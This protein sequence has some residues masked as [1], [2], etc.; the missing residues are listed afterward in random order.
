[1]KTY[2]H[3]KNLQKIENSQLQLKSRIHELFMRGV[4]Y[5]QQ[6]QFSKASKLYAQVL[7]LNPN[8]FDAMHLSGVVASQMKNYLIAVELISKSIELNPGFAE[9]F[10][11]LGNALK[12]LKRFD[13]ALVCYKRAIELKPDFIEAHNNCGEA[14]RDLKRYEE[15]L[16]KYNKAIELKP[17]YAFA[18]LNRGNV[19]KEL[20]RSEEAII[21]YLKAIKIKS[22]FAE[23][24]NN[25]GNIYKDLNQ[26]KLAVESYGRAIELKPNYN[27]VCG[28]RLHTK[29]HMCDWH[30][31]E[32]SVKCLSINIYEGKKVSPCLPVLALTDSLLIQFKA[33]ETWMNDKHPP[34]YLLGPILKHQKR[35]KIKVGYY[36]EDFREHPVTYLTVQLYELHNKNHF[37]LFAFYYGPKDTS[38]IHKRIA[39][40]FDSFI[41][42]SQ[43]SDREVAELSRKLSIDIAVDLTG[44]TGNQRAGIFALRVA[45]IQLSYLGYLGTMGAEF[46][47]YLLAD[48]VTI[49][50]ESQKYYKEKIVYL[51]SYQVNDN[52]RI[53][54]DRV[55]EKNQF[56]LP[57]NGFVF[58][59][60][61]NNYKITP[62]TFDAWMRIIKAVPNS[63]LFLYCENKWAESNL[64]NEAEKRGVN[65]TRLSF[66]GR[67]ERSQ[68]LAR[69]RLADLFLDTLPYNSGATASDA[70]WA[71]LPVLTC[72][73]ES[74]A[75]RVAASLLKA[76]ELPELIT[77]TQSEYEATAIELAN[78]AQL[79]NAVKS[80]LER[81]RLKTSL[82]DT[83]SFT[84]N[85]ENAYIKMYQRYQADLPPD[86]I[87]IDA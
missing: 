24:H 48:A 67:I 6:G 58:C 16:I 57:L 3:K 68:Y 45:P 81:N 12:E 11:N 39:S 71:G 21:S 23:A 69:Y 72:M 19:L 14:L 18:Y 77:S 5:H 28:T 20:N 54:S 52:K 51:P 46:Y 43:I 53:I 84:K 1:M 49:P 25:L 79:Y 60:F 10:S 30:E 56:N 32:Y 44:L 34:N 13:D 27:Y 29:M 78:N 64:M 62:T 47:D 75:S 22:D 82:F 73:G 87:Y 63:V 36:S 31:F 80:K 61:S 26:L 7:I 42:I 2:D 65:K 55:F 41:D 38:D 40:N 8:H 86:N 33:S 83:Q 70:L 76:I 37:E 59:C 4:G 15:A 35:R 50:V 74:F 9:A 17:D 85:I 66:C